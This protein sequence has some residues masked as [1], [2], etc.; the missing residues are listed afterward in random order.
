M[1][2][3]PLHPHCNKV[4]LLGIVLLRVYLCHERSL[5][6]L[7]ICAHDNPYRQKRKFYSRRANAIVIVYGF[8]LFQN[9]LRKSDLI[10]PAI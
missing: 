2:R 7:Q 8:N 3:R 1:D 4:L 6:R 9:I 5:L 10:T